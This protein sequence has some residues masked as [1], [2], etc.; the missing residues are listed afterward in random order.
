MVRDLFDVPHQTERAEEADGVVGDVDFPPEEALAGSALI[1]VVI[2]VPPLAQGE[3]R[4]REAIFR[5]VAGYVARLADPVHKRI[6]RE[7]RMVEKDG[8]EKKTDKEGRPS[9]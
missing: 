6:D 4:E 1:V 8:A 3:N 9:S 7:G 2:V 5:L